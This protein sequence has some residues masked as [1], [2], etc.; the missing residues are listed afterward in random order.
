MIVNCL[1]CSKE[2]ESINFCDWDCHVKYSESIGMEKLCP[3][4]LPI[5][6]IGDKMMEHEHADHPNY[7]YP[8]RIK[9]PGEEK[10]E[11]IDKDGNVVGV[12]NNS[13]QAHALIF[14][15]GN[16]AITIY[17]CRYYIWNVCQ[18]KYVGGLRGIDSLYKDAYIVNIELLKK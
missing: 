16:L 7:Q 10:D 12:Y 2:N 13:N 14:N 17:E 1:F 18:N 5:T 15:D 3:N 8:I 6:C 4:N 9:N 11:L